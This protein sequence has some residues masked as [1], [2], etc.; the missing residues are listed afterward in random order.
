MGTSMTAL[1]ATIGEMQTLTVSSSSIIP[2]AL[3]STQGKS[4]SRPEFAES[5]EKL[6]RKSNHDRKNRDDL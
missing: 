1:S 2:W 5:R 6:L 3:Q 4:Q